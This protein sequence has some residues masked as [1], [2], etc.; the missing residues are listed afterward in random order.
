MCNMEQGTKTSPVAETWVPVRGFEGLYEVSDLGR[1]RSL[2]RWIAYI[3]K[4]GKPYKTLTKGRILSLKISKGYCL[5]HLSH[6]GKAI[7][8]TVH[9]LVAEAFIPNPDNLPE[10][11]HKDENTTNNAVSNL[12]WC[13]QL[14]NIHY[15]TGIERRASKKRKAIAK[16]T[17]DGTYICTYESVI[18]A[19]NSVGKGRRGT[20]LISSSANN[21]RTS[22]YGYV[23]RYV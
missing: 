19:A 3:S 12:E 5:A 17:K 10:I 4:Y 6:Q 18:A 2:D 22:A 15:G 16:F 20:A 21:K 7:H 9:R 14:Y 23:W 1:V 13:E 11:N 8:K